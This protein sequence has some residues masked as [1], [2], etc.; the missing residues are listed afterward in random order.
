MRSRWGV[1]I[2]TRAGMAILTLLC[3]SSGLSIFTTLRSAREAEVR[4]IQAVAGCESAMAQ[5]AKVQNQNEALQQTVN[6]L[7]AAI[8]RLRLRDVSARLTY[9]FLIDLSRVG[10]PPEL[11]PQGTVLEIF[12]VSA[13]RRA[14][15]P[16]RDWTGTMLLKDPE[17]RLTATEQTLAS[18]TVETV[19][20]PSI[21]HARV[22]SSFTG[23]FGS[24]ARPET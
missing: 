7:G 23:E 2:P 24:F 9:Q 16:A 10:R 3:V 5:L 8:D 17:M 19:D 22:F 21:E 6:R 12:A 11:F 20:G 4:R 13:V 15:A 18:R 14:A 1:P